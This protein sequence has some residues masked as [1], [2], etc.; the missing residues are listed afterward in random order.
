MKQTIAMKQAAFE[1]LMREHGFQ[2]LGATTY[3]GSFIYQRTW[4]RTD[5]VAFYGPMESTYKIMAHISYGV[6]IIQLSRTGT[7]LAPA[8]IPA[9]SGQSTPSGKSSG[10]PGTSCKE[11]RS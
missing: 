5:E 6:P 9:P 8:T 7:H 4:H 10:A 2:Y 1:E 3:D 11:G